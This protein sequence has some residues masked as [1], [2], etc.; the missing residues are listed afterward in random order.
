[1][2]LSYSS[3]SEEDEGTDLRHKHYRDTHSHTHSDYEPDRRFTYNSHKVRRKP[4][5][6]SQKGT[7]SVCA[8]QRKEVWCVAC[9]SQKAQQ[10]TSHVQEVKLDN[11]R[12][13]N[14]DQHWSPVPSSAV[15]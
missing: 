8:P 9:A 2:E 15:V 4:N 3:S 11:S 1:M 5:D 6:P 10:G 14:K 13:L 7:C 12:E